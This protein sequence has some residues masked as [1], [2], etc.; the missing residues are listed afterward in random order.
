MNSMGF[1]FSAYSAIWV[2]LAI[3]LFSIHSREKKLR[4]EVE[5]LKKMLESK[6][7]KL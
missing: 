4:S 1:L 7:H 5:R 3:Y 6:N 2:I